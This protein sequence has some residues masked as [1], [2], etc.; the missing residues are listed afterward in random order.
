M[1]TKKKKNQI[2][3]QSHIPVKHI[4]LQSNDYTVKTPSQKPI[5]CG[6]ARNDLTQSH[7]QTDEVNCSLGVFKGTKWVQRKEKLKAHRKRYFYKSASPRASAQDSRAHITKKL[8]N[9]AS[10]AI[11][12]NYPPTT[13][14]KNNI[15]IY[16][17]KKKVA[18]LQSSTCFFICIFKEY[19]S[20]KRTPPPPLPMFSFGLS[21]QKW[22]QLSFTWWT[23][24]FFFFFT[25]NTY[26]RPTFLKLVALPSSLHSK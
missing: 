19:S 21:T 16:I 26:N 24:P 23:S 18:T 14:P 6:S 12:G 25:L 15:Y 9:E 5:S 8:T 22:L 17:K 7:R 13:H 11:P 10:P 20:S 1:S 2:Q 3:Q 4:H